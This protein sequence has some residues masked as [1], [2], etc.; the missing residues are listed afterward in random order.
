MT[1]SV[2]STEQ[3]SQTVIRVL[4]PPGCPIAHVNAVPELTV[5]TVPLKR[6]LKILSS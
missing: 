4:C 6:F 3:G 2:V 5:P 1:H